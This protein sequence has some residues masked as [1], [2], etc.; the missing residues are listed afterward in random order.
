MHQRQR[1]GVVRNLRRVLLE[2]GLRGERGLSIGGELR[3]A[4]RL[5]KRDS[6]GGS[7]SEDES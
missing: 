1:D 5:S 6:P 3:W 2:F 4:W 7:E